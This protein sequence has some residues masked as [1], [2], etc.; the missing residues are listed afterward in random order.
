M[1]DTPVDTAETVL[2]MNP[3]SGSGDHVKDIHDRATLLGYDVQE[4]QRENHAIELA[5][6]A[7]ERGVD[8]VVAVGGDGTLNEVIRGVAA[9]DA[10]DTVTVGVVPAGT[11]ND[12]ATNIGITDI[13][14]AFHVLEDGKRRRLDLGIADDR[15]F[16]N[17]CVAGITAKASGETPSALKS[18][19]GVLAY[20]I[21][22]LKMATEFSGINIRASIREGPTEETAWEG[23]ATVVLVGN[24]RRFSLSRS[25]QANLEDGLFDVAIIEAI[26]SLHL[27]EERLV[28]WILDEEGEHLVRFLASS[29][30]I[31]IEGASPA[32]FSFDGEMADL[33]S[34]Q[35]SND[36]RALEMAV[37]D[38]YDRCPQG[39]EDG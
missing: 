11:G 19:F 22:T 33:E 25:E 29:L 1:T 39:G 36:R 7:A 15:L 13:D 38:G 5:R 3:R 17:S 26:D 30:E 21:T 31:E 18:R 12:F 6:S 10:L 28:E 32:T 34:V 23:P 2:V 4:T 20:V 24:G 27:A 37:G 35:L 16:L 8:Q 14:D 9:A